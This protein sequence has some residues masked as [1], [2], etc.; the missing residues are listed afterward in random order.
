MTILADDK[1]CVIQFAAME[2]S[3]GTRPTLPEL[4]PQTVEVLQA[5]TR[6]LAGVAPRSVEVLDGCGDPAAVP[7]AR[8]P[9]RSLAGPVRPDGPGTVLEAPMV[10]R[11][12]GR[13]SAAGHVTRGS[14]P[15][16]RRVVTL[17]CRYLSGSGQPGG[18]LAA[19]GTAP[20]CRPQAGEPPRC[21]SLQKQ[22]GRDTGRSPAVWCPCGQSF[23]P[24]FGTPQRPP[25]PQSARR[26][27]D[28][29]RPGQRPAGDGL[30]RLLRIR[31]TGRV[32]EC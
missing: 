18:G 21:A 5:A 17:A 4:A 16:H 10:T 28:V 32:P 2:S 9:G 19:A 8:C 26:A 20:A 13:L 27:G 24:T 7:D 30:P 15:G 25:R 3:P 31:R 12:A 11:L 1:C 14:E 29:H 6:V 22:P 23:Q